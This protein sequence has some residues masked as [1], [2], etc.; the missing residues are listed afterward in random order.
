MGAAV[1]DD[2]ACKASVKPS[3]HADDEAH[4]AA[5]P[6]TG[7]H[8]GPW[9]VNDDSAESYS[10]VCSEMLGRSGRRTS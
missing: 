9:L 7:D 4:L 10:W 5:P 1:P 6:P 8:H 2:R 3:K